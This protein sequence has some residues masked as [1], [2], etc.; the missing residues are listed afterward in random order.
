MELPSPGP[1]KLWSA[2]RSPTPPPLPNHYIEWGH[3]KRAELLQRRSCRCVR[4]SG[5]CSSQSKG[6]EV[7]A[8]ARQQ[9]RGDRAERGDDQGRVQER[10]Q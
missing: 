4:P 1:P 9:V 2:E 8:N 10:P 3:R 6:H 7:P 5:L